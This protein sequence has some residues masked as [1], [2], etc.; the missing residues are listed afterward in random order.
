MRTEH[1]DGTVTTYIYCHNESVAPNVQEVRASV[2]RI[3][4]MCRDI[5]TTLS[6]LIDLLPEVH[7]RE[8]D[9][10]GDSHL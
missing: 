3:E 6:L 4:V 10:S 5:L 7:E 8:S 1:R 9:E 2:A